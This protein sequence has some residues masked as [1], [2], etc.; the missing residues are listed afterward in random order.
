MSASRAL[1]LAL[2]MLLGAPAADAQ[3]IDE[4]QDRDHQD[5]D[6]AYQERYDEQ[7]ERTAAPTAADDEEALEAFLARAEDLIRDRN[8]RAANG[9]HYRVQTDDPRLDARAAV[10]LLE[11]FRSWF[12]EYWGDRLA[13]APYEQTSR[14][15]MFYSFYKFNRLLEGDFRF[16]DVRPKG[17]YG[18]LFDVITLH[19]DADG[20]EVLGDAL[21]HEAAHQL[22]DRRLYASGHIPSLWLSEG[23]ASYFGYTRMDETGTFLPG[24][25]GGKATELIRGVRGKSGESR[26]R[27]KTLR[28]LFGSADSDAAPIV[29][30]V[31]SIEDPNRFYG[32]N[33]QQNYGVSWLLVHYLLHGDDGA[34][35]DGFLRYLRG[36][37]S[38]RRGPDE[39]YRSIGIDAG[40]LE[41]RLARYLKRVKAR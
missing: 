6:R 37:T 36:E 39:L 17:H 18:S 22:V 25:I 35:A 41:R 38:G 13:L 14:V 4:D 29:E 33:A 40:E 7:A 1:L 8:H 19:T 26:S 10:A 31:L 34:H 9:T 12:D 16:R 32:E 21:V 2:L 15:F 27:L 11:G 23:L 3:W 28:R 5:Q 20:P 30:R 24:E